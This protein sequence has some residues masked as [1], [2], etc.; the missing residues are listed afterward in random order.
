MDDKF[1]LEIIIINDSCFLPDHIWT[2][3]FWKNVSILC[4]TLVCTMF[5]QSLPHGLLKFI[6]A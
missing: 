2:N 1:M 5:I 4:K 3:V 6:T